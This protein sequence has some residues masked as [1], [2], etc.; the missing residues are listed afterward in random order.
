MFKKTG[1]FLFTAALL[2]TLLISP[3]GELNHF[4]F[5]LL[6]TGRPPLKPHCSPEGPTCDRGERRDLLEAFPGHAL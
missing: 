5:F 1:S 4:S 3:S 6:W 2:P